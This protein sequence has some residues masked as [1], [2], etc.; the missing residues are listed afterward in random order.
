MS[1]ANLIPAKPGLA[2]GFFKAEKATHGMFPGSP[3]VPV[4]RVRVARALSI[5]KADTE[6]GIDKGLGFHVS[7]IGINSAGGLRFRRAEPLVQVFGPL[8]PGDSSQLISITFA[9]AVKGANCIVRASLAEA[10]DERVACELGHAFN[11]LY[12]CAPML[13]AVENNSKSEPAPVAM[14]IFFRN[15]N[16]LYVSKLGLDGSR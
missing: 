12:P 9:M 16:G 6:L 10:S 14:D 11:M 3:A 13:V 15:G 2:Y 5:L 7:L 1:A 4:T 8:E